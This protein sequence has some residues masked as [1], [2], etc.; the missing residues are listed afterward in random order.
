M[1]NDCVTTSGHFA[2]P[3][4]TMRNLEGG[5]SALKL[6][7]PARRAL[8][9]VEVQTEAVVSSTGRRD[10]LAAHQQ[11]TSGPGHVR[12]DR[13]EELQALSD[14]GG[15]VGWYR[16]ESG[17]GEGTQKR[18][19]GRER[20]SEITGISGAFFRS[21]TV[22]PC[23]ASPWRPGPSARSPASLVAPWPP[24]LLRPLSFDLLSAPGHFPER[25]AAAGR[26]GLRPS[27]PR[28][29]PLL[30]GEGLPGTLIHLGEQKRGLAAAA[31]ATRREARPWLC[32][33][34]VTA[35][36][37]V[38]GRPSSEVDKDRSGVI[39]DNELQQALSNG[40]WTPFNPVTVR[41]IISMFDREN[42]AGV[43]FSEF[44]GVW[45]Y[46]TDWQNVFRTYDRD[47]SGMIDKNELKQ[48]LSGFGK[49]L[50]LTA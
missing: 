1:W 24:G 7:F 41:S 30:R 28:A 23:S 21:I 42:K 49:T 43:N 35:V 17:C 15:D 20:S 27:P 36:S 19:Q 38:P 37:S 40:T 45:K 44:T 14:A 22:L 2:Q 48:A 12:A 50:V 34:D 13:A 11:G 10:T 18:G 46:I 33:G 29:G 4:G 25:R 26:L 16:E 47:N 9:S 39:S 5:G 3:V 31:S 6:G 8:R 32:A